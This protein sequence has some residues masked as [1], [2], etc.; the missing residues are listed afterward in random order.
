MED[1]EDYLAG[2]R[3]F[4]NFFGVK[5]KEHVLLLPTFE[6]L[7]ND[8]PALKAL[9]DVG[10]EIGAEVSVAVMEPCSIHGNPPRPIAQAI[11]SSD[12][13][14]AMGDKRQ[15]PISGHGLTA[16]RAR[17]DYGAKQADL[18][19]GKGAPEQLLARIP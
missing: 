18:H 11:E 6:F 4:Y 9:I 3:N 17:W 15:N 2:A 7:E 5:P 13:F 12:L 14:L 16:L 1:Y 10:K 8:P 19:G